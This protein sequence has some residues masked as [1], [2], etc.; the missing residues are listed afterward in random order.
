M[1]ITKRTGLG[2]AQAQIHRRGRSALCAVQTRSIDRRHALFARLGVDRININLTLREHSRDVDQKSS[3]VVAENL[4]LC[5]IQ[6]IAAV[7]TVMLPFRIDQTLLL[8]I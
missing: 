3:T 1:N 2:P 8:H 4:D 6:T 7:L 5:A